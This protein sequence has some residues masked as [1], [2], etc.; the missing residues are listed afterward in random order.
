MQCGAHMRMLLLALIFAARILPAQPRPKFDVVS[1]KPCSDD[2][3][4]NGERSGGRG[5][6]SPTTFSMNCTPV[7][8][9]I[10][11]AYVMFANGHV[12]PDPTLTIEGGP[13]W[14]LSERYQI[15]A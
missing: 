1:V 8:G 3:A 14:I 9:L 4:G 12:N 10:R 13:A 7:M 5:P 2:G 6:N 11:H 15:E